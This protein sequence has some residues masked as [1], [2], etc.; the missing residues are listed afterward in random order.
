MN[1]IR[2]NAKERMKGSCRVCP[3]CDGRACAGEVPGMGGLGDGAAFKNNVRALAAVSLNMR[4][5]HEVREPSAKCA[6]LGL[7]LSMPVVAAPIGGMFNFKEAVSEDAYVKA[8]LEGSRAAGV[9]GCTGDGVPPVINCTALDCIVGL[10]GYGIPFI[11]PWENEELEVKMERALASGCSIM[12]MDIDA[13]GL[14]TLRKMGRPVGPKSVRELSRI[15]DKAHA[16]G[17]KFLLKG[18]MTVSDALLAA[19]TGAD[20]IVVSNHGGRVFAATPGTVEVLPAIAGAVGGRLSIMVDG[21]VRSGT[22]VFTMLALGANVVGIGRPLA[23]AAIGGGSEGVR[24]YWDGIR[25]E[26]EQ[27]MI[28]TGCKDIAS[29]T[30]SAV[31]QR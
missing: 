16:A 23:V 11:K 10:Q 6:W 24:A 29:I 20:G 14:V 25:A 2:K 18:V 4:L 5:I 8:I 22:D 21:G 13:A 27:T 3:V 31:F 12:G 17:V 30:T 9:I 15:V 26:L 7:E 1:D 28:L 19:E